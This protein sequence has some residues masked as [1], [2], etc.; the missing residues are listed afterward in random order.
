[1]GLEKGDIIVEQNKMRTL[2]DMTDG[3]IDVL[4]SQGI[5]TEETCKNLQRQINGFEN[6]LNTLSSY[7]YRLLSNLKDKEESPK[8]SSGSPYII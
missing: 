5:I 6:S 1:M 2:I 3:M 4:F 7:C 8:T